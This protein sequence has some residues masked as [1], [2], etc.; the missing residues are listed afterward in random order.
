MDYKDYYAVLGVNRNASDAEIKSAY[1]KLAMQYHPDRNRGSQQAEEKFKEIN[2]AYQVL[3]DPQK[4]AHYDRLGSAYHDWQRRGSTGGFDWSRWTA[5]APGG[6]SVDIGD[7]N[8]LFGGAGGFSDFFRTI[9]GGMPGG[10]VEEMFS[11]AGA[12]HRPAEQPVSI[13]LDEAMH[14]TT[15]TLEW[16]GRRLEV[17]IPAGARNGTRVRVP[18]GAPQG[19]IYLRIQVADDARFRLDGGD[20]HSEQEIDLFTAVLGGDVTV[21]TPGGDV[22][23]TIPA[24]TQPGQ[25][26]R[27][28][29]RGLPALKKSSQA[30]DL[31]VTVRV[32]LP[33]RLTRKQREL[34]QQLAALQ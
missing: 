2:E 19:D 33:K 34:F 27:L 10:S 25:V 6:V 26:F 15:R 21:A 17:K 12:R 28:R 24:G 7:L 29:G 9:F 22:V 4:R 5:G 18:V 20:V 14:G 16:N 30:G 32:R 23:L 13:S 31:Y 3:S 8:D 1:R 11:Q